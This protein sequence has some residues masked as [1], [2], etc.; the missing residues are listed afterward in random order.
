MTFKTTDSSQKIYTI[1]E[2]TAKI[3]T[4]IEETFP[5]VW[6]TGEISNF[7]NPVSGHFYFT[8]KDQNAQINAVMF[9]GQ[10]RNLTFIPEDGMGIAGLG[11]ISLYEPRGSY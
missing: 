2:L 10:N 6:V 4:L 7:R 9:R 3:K 1:S 8:L 5:F 11:R